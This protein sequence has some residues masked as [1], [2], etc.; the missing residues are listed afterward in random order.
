[1]TKREAIYRIINL[2]KEHHADSRLSKRLIWNVITSASKVIIDRELRDKKLFKQ[3]GNLKSICVPMEKIST[4]LCAC[5]ELPSN[6][7]IYRSVNKLPK[8]FNSILGY[9]IYDIRTIDGSKSIK[10]TTT[11]SALSSSKIKGNNEKY[12]FIEDDY[13][14]LVKDTY[15]MVSLTSIFD[16]NIEDWQCN[17]SNSNIKKE[18]SLFLDEE[19]GIP[20]RLYDPVLKMAEDEILKTFKQL[21]Y[22]TAN[23]KNSNIETK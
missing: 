7:F 3:V 18:C 22:D 1:M 4:N 21:Y 20:D 13:L 6:C 9:Y 15:E 23:N 12:A 17:K 11:R 5:V 8:M 10:Y 19:F 14:Y 2:F 16:D